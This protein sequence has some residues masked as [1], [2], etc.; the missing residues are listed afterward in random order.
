MLN[1]DKSILGIIYWP[2][3]GINSLG[4]INLKSILNKYI[5]AHDYKKQNSKHEKYEYVKIYTFSLQGQPYTL[6]FYGGGVVEEI[7]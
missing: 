7:L 3:S 5:C 2:G 4:K 1:V 6:I